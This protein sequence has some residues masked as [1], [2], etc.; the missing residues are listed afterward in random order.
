[1]LLLGK[2]ENYNDDAGEPFPITLPGEEKSI[3][4]KKIEEY[5]SNDFFYY[6]DIYIKQKHHGK[7]FDG[8]WTELPEWYLQLVIH[9]DNAIEVV[10]LHNEREAYRSLYNGR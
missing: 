2:I 6:Y 3:S 9:F 7:P 4:S 8:G 5:L 10:K 1:L